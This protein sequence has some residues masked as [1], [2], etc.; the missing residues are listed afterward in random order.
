MI[1]KPSRQQGCTP[2]VRPYSRISTVEKDTRF[3]G[4]GE[5]G[6]EA[7]ELVV[8]L[9]D[10]ASEEEKLPSSLLTTASG[11]ANNIS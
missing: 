2:I 6:G 9:D 1:G 11:H 8:L 10:D 4:L 7:E 3:E 5:R